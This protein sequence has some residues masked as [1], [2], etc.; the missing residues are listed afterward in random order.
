MRLSQ[1]LKWIGFFTLL[2]LVYIHMQMN[3]IH[4]AY[5]GKL[6]EQ[7]LRS[8]NEDS[9]YLTYAILSMKSSSNLGYKLLSGE[10]GMEF[11]DPQNIMV[12]T[13]SSDELLGGGELNS[14]E[15]GKHSYLLSLL[16][17]GAQA[18]AKGHE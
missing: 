16:P 15:K 3:I 7:N 11:V 14:Q 8:L 12:V 1:L 4:L 18:E 5:E 13:T 17:F 6:K 10:S 9:G 2:A